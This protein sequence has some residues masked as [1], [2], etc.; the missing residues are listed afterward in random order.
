LTGRGIPQ[1]DICHLVT[2][3]Q[4]GKPLDLKS[5]RKHFADEIKTGAIELHLL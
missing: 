4:T 5:L 2:N 1:K 3:A